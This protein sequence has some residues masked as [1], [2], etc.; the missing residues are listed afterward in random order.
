MTLV[1]D[2]D[3]PATDKLVLLAMADFC[4]DDGKHCFPSCETIMR[5]TNLSE[6]KIRGVW[7]DYRKKELLIIAQR[8][9]KHNPTHYAFSLPKLQAVQLPGVHE[10]Q[11][12]PDDVNV[13]NTHT[14]TL[15]VNNVIPKSDSK[16]LYKVASALAEVCRME[17]EL[18]R[19]A[20]FAEA[21]RLVSGGV[22]AEDIRQH[23][24]PGGWWQT[25]Y[26]KGQRGEPPI[27]GEVRKFWNT[28][29][30]REK[31]D[32]EK[33]QEELHDGKVDDNIRR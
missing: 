22:T 14:H 9:T 15:S 23:Y 6:R 7:A 20:L 25:S 1:W 16:Q 18:N 3:L 31:T 32:R 11:E 10:V 28:W 24:G 19:P 5:K 33:F 30:K 26:W 12:S 29:D 27:L 8:A 13:V 2:A 4:D 17:L 21:K